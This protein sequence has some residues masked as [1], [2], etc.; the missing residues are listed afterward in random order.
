MATTRFAWSLS[1]R[2]THPQG[3]RF[4][5]MR[6]RA[7]P[8]APVTVT[9][10]AWACYRYCLSGLIRCVCRALCVLPVLLGKV[11]L[12]CGAVQ[13]GAMRRGAASEGDEWQGPNLTTSRVAAGGENHSAASLLLCH[14]AIP[15]QRPFSNAA[16][17][18]PRLFSTECRFPWCC[19]GL[20]PRLFRLPHL[21]LLIPLGILH[22]PPP[23]SGKQFRATE[24]HLRFPLRST[25]HVSSALF[26]LFRF[27]C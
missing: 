8:A 10:R 20:L 6:G 15:H 9:A 5:V 11:T 22:S 27:V 24:S 3:D 17:T 16:Q 26:P 4:S 2:T 1:V 18:T 21:P 13:R 23:P 7:R 12:R 14:L 25:A 19:R